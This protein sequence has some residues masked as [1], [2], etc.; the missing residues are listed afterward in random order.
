MISAGVFIN[1]LYYWYILY[2]HLNFTSK[3]C[4]IHQNLFGNTTTNDAPI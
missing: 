1:S 2:S 4:S 3:R